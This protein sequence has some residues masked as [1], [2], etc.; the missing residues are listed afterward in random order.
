MASAGHPWI[1][2]GPWYRWDAPGVPEA[3]RGSKPEIQKYAGFDF[4]AEFLREP[5]RSLKWKDEDYLHRTIA[6]TSAL[7]A[8]LRA[9]V[10][11]AQVDAAVAIVDQTSPLSVAA[12]EEFID[13][14]FACF[15]EDGR[16]RLIAA[17]VDPASGSYIEGVAARRRWLLEEI[18]LR[19]NCPTSLGAWLRE[20]T[21]IRKLYKP[22]HARSYL[23]VAEL[24]CDKPGLPRVDRREVAEAGFVIRRVR[25]RID[26]PKLALAA[27]AA[28]Q[29]IAL[30]R[31]QVAYLERNAKGRIRAAAGLVLQRQLERPVVKKQHELLERWSLGK[32]ALD[33]LAAA[34]A[35]ALESEAWIPDPNDP[36]RGRW[37]PLTQAQATPRLDLGGEA[38]EGLHA[39]TPDPREP[40]HSAARRTMYFGVIPTG[41]REAEA[42]GAP[43]FDERYIYEIRCFVRR[44]PSKPGCPGELVWS[45][46]TIGYRVALDADPEGTANLPLSITVPSFRDIKAFADNIATGGAG[47]M[48]VVQPPDSVMPLFGTFPD[49]S[50]GERTGIGQI[51]F[52]A[53]L[54]LFLIALFLVFVFLP[55]IVFLFQLFFLLRLKFCIPPSVDFSVGVTAELKAQL[56]LDFGAGASFDFSAQVFAGEKINNMDE[57]AS[58]VD[59]QLAQ[60]Y[61]GDLLAALLA[62]PLEIRMQRV[63]DL[64]TDFRDSVDPDLASDLN[65]GAAPETEEPMNPPLPVAGGALE[66][67]PI[68]DPRA[69]FG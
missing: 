33:E 68:I 5:Q 46:P 27:T 60:V 30:A 47:G 67:Y 12:Q 31:D 49:A 14:R 8:T 11:D 38:F 34:G 10:G 7:P 50:A 69:V 25:A 56:D 48:R 58:W 20:K 61:D 26:D 13:E 45:A 17:L 21:G 35:V 44:Q 2:T 32:L 65:F 66:Y 41:G 52:I 29:D 43:R 39:L 36:L 64:R 4:A 40:N 9:I 37:K 55:I 16:E 23:V 3:G 53:I 24:S 1:L 28:L 54:L 6:N 42:N 57:L 51:C 19:S 62:A 22:A 59:V 15:T 63:V 18:T